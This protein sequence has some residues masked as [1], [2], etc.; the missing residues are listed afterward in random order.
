MWHVGRRAGAASR[1]RTAVGSPTL[2]NIDGLGSPPRRRSTGCRRLSERIFSV[3]SQLYD[4][5]GILIMMREVGVTNRSIYLPSS[6]TA[7][8][9][10]APIGDLS[11]GWR[12]GCVPGCILWRAIAPAGRAARA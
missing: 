1:R 4:P 3:F 6:T 7:Q 8:W 10:I 2:H 9:L 5:P 11:W 12:I